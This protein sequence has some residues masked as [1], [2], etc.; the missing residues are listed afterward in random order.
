MSKIAEC[1]DTTIMFRQNGQTEETVVCEGFVES[2]PHYS[3]ISMIGNS[4]LTRDESRKQETVCGK[5]R[6]DGKC[7]YAEL[8]RCESTWECSKQEV[9]GQLDTE[10]G[11]VAEYKGN[12]G[13]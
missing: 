12:K 8:T 1:G 7:E 3:F 4:Q 11:E 10:S 6:A 2:Y 9:A 13:T 5:A